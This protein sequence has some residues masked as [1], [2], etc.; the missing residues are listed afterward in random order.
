MKVSSAILAVVA[1]LGAAPLAAQ[2][3]ALGTGRCGAGAAPADCP[4][5]AVAPRPADP[6]TGA[7]NPAPGGRVTGPGVLSGP[8]GPG[9]GAGGGRRTGPGVITGP[10]DTP[11]GPMMSAQEQREQRNRMRSFR[12][13]QECA[14]YRDRH[15]NEMAARAAERRAG[16][17]P[18]P[19]R[20]VCAGLPR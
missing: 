10:Q 1:A 19:R 2:T 7:G 14:A 8:P 4:R 12:T 5:S 16:V 13:Y 18:A 11:G 6:P 15:R 17:P 3:G 20:D 9:A